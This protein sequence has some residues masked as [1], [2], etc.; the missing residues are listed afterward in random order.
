MRSQSISESFLISS[1]GRANQGMLEPYT[2]PHLATSR[3]VV[4]VLLDAE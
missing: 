1:L 2:H 3:Y 4:A